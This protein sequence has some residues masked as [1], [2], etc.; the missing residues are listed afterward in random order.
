[1]HIHKHVRS[2]IFFIFIHLPAKNL[3]CVHRKTSKCLRKIFFLNWSALFG[4]PLVA[5]LA[6]P[7]APLGGGGHVGRGGGAILVVVLAAALRIVRR[8]RTSRRTLDLTVILRKNIE[9]K[10]LGNY[11]YFAFRA[12][13]MTK[14]FAVEISTNTR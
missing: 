3:C 13:H 5:A 9:L 6:P 10:S 1:M 7:G 2:Y 8:G 11:K 12:T 4:A 14:A